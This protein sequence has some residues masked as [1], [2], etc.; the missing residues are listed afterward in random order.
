MT[1]SVSILQLEDIET[2]RGVTFD[3]PGFCSTHNLSRMATSTWMLETIGALPLQLRCIRIKMSVETFEGDCFNT[4]D[5]W[6]GVH[7]LPWR[8]I[9]RKSSIV[10]DR[11]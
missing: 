5:L 6:T 2:L 7:V 11:S 9:F 3:V 10:R 8:R 1:D 4:L